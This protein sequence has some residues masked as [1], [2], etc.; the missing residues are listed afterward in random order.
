MLLLRRFPFASHCI[1]Y[2]LRDDTSKGEPSRPGATSTTSEELFISF[3]SS[4]EIPLLISYLFVTINFGLFS[5][6]RAKAPNPI[7]FAYN[8]DSG[9]IAARAAPSSEYVPAII[10]YKPVILY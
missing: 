9:S 2:T 8:T 4:L 3:A 6:S 7:S 5:G 10:W 1:A